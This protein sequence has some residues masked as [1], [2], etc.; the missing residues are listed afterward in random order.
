MVRI[1]ICMGFLREDDLDKQI[2][3]GRIKWMLKKLDAR[4]WIGLIWLR[5]GTSG[6]LFAHESEPAVYNTRGISLVA[7][8]ILAFQEGLF[9]M[10]LVA[11]FT[12]CSLQVPYFPAPVRIV[13]I[14]SPFAPTRLYIILL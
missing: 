1:N 3:D 6:G 11:Q 7:E 8:G 9:P 13:I 12:T 10:L 4:E 5:T 2:V 14:Y